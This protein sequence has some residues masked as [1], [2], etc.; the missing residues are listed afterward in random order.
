MRSN[1]SSRDVEQRLVAVRRAGVVD[2]DVEVAERG[3][4]RSDES[5]DVGILR[6]VG[7]AETRLPSSGDDFTRNALAARDVDVVDDDAGALGGIAFRDA[8]AEPRSCAGD[9]R[10]F[11]LESHGAPCRCR[12]RLR[13]ID[14]AEAGAGLADPMKRRERPHAQPPVA[15]ELRGER[16]LAGAV[17]LR[18]RSARGRRSTSPS[19]PDRRGRADARRSARGSTGRRARWTGSVISRYSGTGTSF[20][21][22]RWT[23]I[24]STPASSVRCFTFCT[25]ASPR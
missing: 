13:A 9:D 21:S 15:R 11:A 18:R 5:R 7:G 1:S 10:H 19:G 17:A 14:V 8:L 12:R 4:R 16:E 24:T 3:E 2:D 23:R 6:H 25:A 22:I 20:L